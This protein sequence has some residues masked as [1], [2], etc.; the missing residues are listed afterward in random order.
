MGGFV[1]FL[2]K[3]VPWQLQKQITSRKKEKKNPKIPNPSPQCS[4]TKLGKKI[5]GIITTEQLCKKIKVQLTGRE[6]K[7]N[8]QLQ[9]V[10]EQPGCL[11]L[12]TGRDGNII[13]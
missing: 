8:R 10:S 12:D 1:V 4:F 9:N 2:N 11:T 13:N 6:K 7:R 3:V 5:H